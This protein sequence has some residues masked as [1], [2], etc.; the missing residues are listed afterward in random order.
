MKYLIKLYI[1]IIIINLTIFAIA[2]P[3]KSP[4]TSSPKKTTNNLNIDLKD[5]RDLYS[6]AHYKEA[7]LKINSYLTNKP[8]DTS[9][10]ILK[11][12]CF[13][14]LNKHQ[15]SINFIK[16]EF[17]NKIISAKYIAEIGYQLFKQ[18]TDTIGSILLI[19]GNSALKMNPKNALA[20]SING[21]AFI[22]KNE[23]DTALFY[24]KK[25]KELITTDDK[26]RLSI[27]YISIL[28]DAGKKQEAISFAQKYITDYPNEAGMYHVLIHCLVSNLQY[29]EA[30]TVLENKIKIEPEYISDLKLKYEIHKK[31]GNKNA[32][33]SD[34]ELLYNAGESFYLGYGCPWASKV[35]SLSQGDSLRYQVITPSANYDFNIRITSFNIENKI[36]FFWNMGN[37]LS[38]KL[39]MLEESLTNAKEQK[40]YYTQS[41]TNVN[42]VN[43]TSAWVSKKIFNDLVNTGTTFYNISGTEKKFIALT[44]KEEND[45]LTTNNED[46]FMGEIVISG[47]SYFVPFIHARSEDKTENIWILNNPSNPLILKMKLGWEIKLNS[48]N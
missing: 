11:S 13:S 1:I 44:E 26:L 3:T 7:L 41:D 17:P 39:S 6:S 40:S 12:L 37:N 45:E 18:S 22:D 24:A 47:K 8:K 42:L 10:I 2:Q 33:C 15:Q 25:L 4:L 29:N 34:A 36:S 32:M 27:N 19:Y 5:A 38:G 16:N 43:S 9:A 23:Y 30:L 46:Y 31:M 35:F 14:Q 48:V 28:F 20:I 21:L